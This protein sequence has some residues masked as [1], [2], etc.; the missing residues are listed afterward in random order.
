MEKSY[1]NLGYILL[2]LIPLTIAGFY[3][4]YFI[5]FP[6]FEAKNDI[7]VHFHAFIAFIWILILIVQP[8]L[9]R[10][11]KLKIH[12]RI[13]RISYVI[14][15]L[16]ILSF[17]PRMLLIFDSGNAKNIFFPLSDSILLII[18]YSLAIYNKKT[19][20]KHMRYMIAMAIVF[21]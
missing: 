9:I 5:Q 6:D 14:F 8:L 1:R 11:K 18:F 10:S 12:R 17:I 7:F 13:G 3:K 20:A 21:L 4:S 2:I 19:V 16:L 15:P